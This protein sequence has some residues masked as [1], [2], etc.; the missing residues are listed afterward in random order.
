MAAADFVSLDE[1]TGIVHTAAIYGEDDYNLAVKIGL[2]TIPMLDDEGKFLPFVKI[3]SGKF[4]KGANPVIIEDLLERSLLYRQEKI[5]HSYPFCY[6]CDTPL[7]YNAVPA[8]FINIQKIKKE[9]L[10]QNEKINWFPGH[11]KHGQ[12]QDILESSPDWNIS[13]SRYWGNP[14]PVWRCT[15]CKKQKIV[16]SISELVNQATSDSR[17]KI[18][19]SRFDLHRPFIDDIRLGCGCGAEMVRITEV[20]DCWVESASMPFAAKHYPFE[21]KEWFEANYPADFI[22]EYSGQVR[23]WFNVLHRVSVALFGKPSFK[24]VSVTGVYLG[25]DGKKMSKSRGNYPDPMLVAQ[26]YGVDALRFYMMSSTVMKAE[27]VIFSETGVEEARNQF[28]N[29]FFNSYKFL[30]LYSAAKFREEWPDVLSSLNRW[31]IFR[32]EET[33]VEVEKFMESYNTIEACKKLRVFISDLSTWYLRRSRETIKSGDL[34]SLEVL[35]VSLIKFCK[36]AASITPF[37]TD[38][39]YR[40]LTGEPSVH[41]S[42]WSSQGKEGRVGSSELVSEMDAVRKICELG[43]AARKG[44]DLKVRQP[45]SLIKIRSGEERITNELAQLILDEL[46]VKSLEWHKIK[47][48]EELKVELDLTLTPEL[49]DEGE[50][51]E[52]VRQVQDLR[53][54][55]GC[56]IKDQIRILA[57]IWPKGWQEYIKRE[58]LASDIIENVVLKIEVL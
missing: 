31:M 54:E 27:D 6:R 22:A 15:S 41:L 55:A 42:D 3:V 47:D 10:K 30:R 17:S 39:V 28:L 16:G 37:L 25:T 44:N 57:P 18:Q 49:K 4:F 11:F 33:L 5:V 21:N 26:K 40:D 12:F 52:L 45:L 8:W 56:S 19:D 9:L 23:A 58:T 20:F 32:T 29:T 36:M 2:P 7:F 35:A 13:R 34:E 14:M 24:N 53:K 46:N 50:A 1:G 43:H 38:Y 51:R 48:E